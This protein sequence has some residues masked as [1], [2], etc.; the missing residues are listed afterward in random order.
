MLYLYLCQFGSSDIKLI[1]CADWKSR[2]KRTS[3][4]V[5]KMLE[6]CSVKFI[7]DKN[8]KEYVGEIPDF[9]FVLSRYSFGK[10]CEAYVFVEF[11]APNFSDEDIYIPLK[12]KETDEI[13]HEFDKCDKI[14]KVIT[15]K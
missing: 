14:N 12:Y 4:I 15:D 1:H 8:N 9:Q 11:K 2:G 5:K 3:E 7:N 10:P 6:F 13:K